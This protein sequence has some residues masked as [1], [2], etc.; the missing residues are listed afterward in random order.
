MSPA[1]QELVRVRNVY[2]DEYIVRRAD[3]DNPARTQLPLYCMNGNKL[4]SVV[5]RMN[6]SRRGLST[7]LHRENIA[8]VV[9]HTYKVR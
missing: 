1:P 3:L 6:W 8:E 9:A 7:T 4:S 5:E 2:G